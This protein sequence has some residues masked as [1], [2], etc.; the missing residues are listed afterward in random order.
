MEEKLHR[1][2]VGDVGF[3]HTKHRFLSNSQVRRQSVSR[4]TRCLENRPTSTIDLHL[5][6][7]RPLEY[8]SRRTP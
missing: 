7:K 6:I 2:T 4:S 3:S 8:I 5:L 1:M